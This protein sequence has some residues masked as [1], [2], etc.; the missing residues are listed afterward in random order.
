MGLILRVSLGSSKVVGSQLLSTYPQLTS[1]PGTSMIEVMDTERQS[2][3]TSSVRKFSVTRMDRA[4][5]P[6]AM[7]QSV[8]LFHD[9]NG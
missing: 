1:K 5:S 7:S 2:T 9:P 6:T 8:W 3:L 4:C